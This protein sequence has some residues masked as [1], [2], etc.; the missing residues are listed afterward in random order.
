MDQEVV[1][2]E[3]VEP[4]AAD[5]DEIKV[6]PEDG[7]AEAEAKP[8]K[9]E[10]ERE[11]ARMQRGIDR[12]TR[13][14]AEAR[15]E[16]AQLR[17][18]N[19]RLRSAGNGDTVRQQDGESDKLTLSRAEIADLIRTEAGKLAPKISSQNAE[20]E[21]RRAVVDSLA[22][23][24]GAERFDALAA[25]LD[26]AVGGLR[27]SDGKPTAVAEAIFESE[28]PK[29]LIEYLADPDNADEAESLAQMAPIKLGRAVAKLEAKL[30][31]KSEPD[32][33][34]PSKRPAPLE[35]IRG[36][37]TVSGAPNPSDTKAWIRWRNEQERKG[38]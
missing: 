26:E 28:S 21:Q 36:Q 9:T 35:A 29:A 14:A 10:A 17:E 1:V 22:K 5:S 19:Q 31:A 13:Q 11:R 32:K 12:K 6:A 34:K 4:A 16:A 7:T 30:A 15:A 3:A 33:P 37:G 8:E 2:P 38:L 18:E 23:D 20:I 25:D 24:W 27:G